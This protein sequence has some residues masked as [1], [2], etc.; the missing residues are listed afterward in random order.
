MEKIAGGTEMLGKGPLTLRL[1]PVTTRAAVYSGFSFKKTSLPTR[2]L[3]GVVP[4]D[5][6][7]AKILKPTNKDRHDLKIKS[8]CKSSTVYIEIIRFHYKIS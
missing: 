4:R 3:Y 5:F 2:V 1:K 6:K 8:R 7:S